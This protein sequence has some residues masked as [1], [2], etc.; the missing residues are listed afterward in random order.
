MT[1]H[2]VKRKSNIERRDSPLSN[3][4]DDIFEN[5]KKD[6]ENT[7]VPFQQ[8]ILDWRLPSVSFP[9]YFEDLESK[10]PLCNMVDK[11]D[12][13]ELQ[14]E[15]PGIDKEKIDIKATE[16][17]IEL[18]GEQSEKTEEKDEN[19]VYNE[20]SYRSIHRTIPFDEEI[21]PNDIDASM[22]NGILNILVPKKV[23]KD[24]KGSVKVNVS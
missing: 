3:K 24:K 22:K 2:N 17:S 15:V 23:P 13:Y 10:V 12:K 14:L 21:K 16:N 6:L 11:G 5:F 4:L 7:F 9:R 8:S 1:S 20:R 19:Y 18:S